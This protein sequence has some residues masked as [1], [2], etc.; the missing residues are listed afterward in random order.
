MTQADGI[1]SHFN[2]QSHRKRHHYNLD[3]VID[4]A[5]QNAASN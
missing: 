5:A 2:E 3:S 1:Q 4:V